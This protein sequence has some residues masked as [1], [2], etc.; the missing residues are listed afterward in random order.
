M[1]PRRFFFADIVELHSR[2]GEAHVCRPTGAGLSVTPYT[3][4]QTRVSI[5]HATDPATH[6]PGPF[7]NEHSPGNVPRLQFFRAMQV[8]SLRLSCLQ[9]ASAWLFSSPAK[10][11]R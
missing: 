4:K 8:M 2:T 5:R 1:R 11:A 6:R 3:T 9:V 7:R 10:R